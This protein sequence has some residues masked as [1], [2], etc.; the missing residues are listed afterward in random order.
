MT[1][2]KLKILDEFPSD[3][4]KYV[5]PTKAD[6][7]KAI[8]YKHNFENVPYLVVIEKVA[9]CLSTIWRQ[10]E[11]PHVNEKTIK[12]RVNNFYEEYKNIL[13]SNPNEKRYT[14]NANIF[15]V[16]IILTIVKRL[17]SN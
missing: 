12:R 11:I 2:K 6:V 9:S 14:T 8:Y 5:L 7:I 13:K 15:K 4:P 16:R 3:L 1:R 17:S 10:T